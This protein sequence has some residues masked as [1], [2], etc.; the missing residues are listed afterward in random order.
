MLTRA[1]IRNFKRFS[2]A[3]L[4]LGSPVVLVGPNNCGKTTALQ[5]LILWNIG[6]RR[7]LERRG[8][9]AG[10]AKERPGVTINRRDVWPVS[11]PSAQLFWRDLHVRKGDH[12]G[13]ENVRIEILV[14]GATPREPWR[15]GLEFDYAN[16][17]SIYCR[18]L[19]LGS[20]KPLARME[21]PE[22]AGA[23][24]MAYL[25]PMSGLAAMEQKLE[26]GAVNVKIGE[27]RTAEVLRNLCYRL[28][29]DIGQE[30]DRWRS[31][32]QQM[33][34]LFWV[35]LHQPEYLPERGEIEMYYQE[36]N[37]GRRLD[38][39][40]SGRGMQQTM[41]L[42]AYLHANP[43]AV[44]L[45]DEPDAHLEVLRQRQTYNLL[46][47]AA[48]EQG[49]QLIVATHSE[50][51][52]NEAGGKDTV[53]A[54]LGRPHVLVDRGAQLR[55]AL[56]SV[57]FDQ[58]LQAEETGWVLYLE[59]STDLQNLQ[60]FAAT[61]KHPA[62]EH[63]ER[64]FVHYTGNQPTRAQEHFH[65][66]REAVPGLRGLA[67]FD[68]LERPLP[69][70]DFLR[71]RMWSR[72]EIEN[73]LWFPEVLEAYAD[74]EDSEQDDLFRRQR[75]QVM[76]SVLE[77]LLPLAALEDREDPWWREEQASRHLGRI[78]DEYFRRLGLPNLMAK[79]D[80]H[81]LAALVPAPLLD[82]EVGR[83]LDDIVA[84]AQEARPAGH[85]PDA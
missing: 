68:H 2:E 47:K 72:A 7:W 5:A 82:A 37:G 34:Q 28:L 49:S 42:L 43:G 84:T 69:V 67:V 29:D 65:A 46:T 35:R 21:V 61:L 14:E 45:L 41:L 44:L 1:V 83:I 3:E 8:G 39:S 85:F 76:R 70:D 48:E 75:R 80:Y 53:V 50:V 66:L 81:Q 13:T 4:E 9:K 33:E 64:P 30:T 25:P 27:G 58:Y 16:E 17:E 62:V 32:A 20:D 57:G 31:F 6:V 40:A 11:V 10:T 71:L 79:R 23:V 18:P 24:K 63:L 73:Y 36:A 60:A 54:M 38:I 51:V 55:K 22:A 77:R 15:C 52:L 74:G 12:R 19:R 78:F 59:G 56:T 26:P